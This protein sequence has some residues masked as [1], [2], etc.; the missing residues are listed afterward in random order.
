MREPIF[1]D[2][3]GL[4]KV[5]ESIPPEKQ[6][7]GEPVWESKSEYVNVEGNRIYLSGFQELWIQHWF[8]K[9]D[10]SCVP[11]FFEQPILGIDMPSVKL[12]AF[13]TYGSGGKNHVPIVMNCELY[14]GIN[15]IRC[16]IRSSREFLA[17]MLRPK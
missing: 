17:I 10:G 14:D 11:L 5:A 1:A 7:K 3:E 13:P 6:K 8:A 2:D 9:P 4:L 16:P 12:T 15:L